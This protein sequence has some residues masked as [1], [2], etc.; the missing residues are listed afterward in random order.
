MTVYTHIYSLLSLYN[1]LVHHWFSYIFAAFLV[2]H[3]EYLVRVE[4]P[5]H[6]ALFQLFLLLI[7]VPLVHLRRFQPCACG[8]F[9]HES[10]RPVAVIG[11]FLLQHSDLRSVLA[12]CIFLFFRY[13]FSLL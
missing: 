13:L 1:E 3:L 7:P 5:L 4:Q 11:V 9:I 2:D 8:Q 10:T 6:L 12:T